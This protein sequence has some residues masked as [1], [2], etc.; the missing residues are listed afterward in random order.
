MGA[1]QPPPRSF[2][3]GF[4]IWWGRQRNRTKIAAIVFSVFIVLV[5]VNS[6]LCGSQDSKVDHQP[7]YNE[8]TPDGSGNREFQSGWDETM[9]LYQAGQLGSACGVVLQAV[10]NQGGVSNTWSALRAQTNGGVSTTYAFFAG[11]VGACEYIV[12]Q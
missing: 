5:A 4:T 8:I 10:R 11:T 2:G 1:Q 3:E 6:T 7:N 9:R 12:G